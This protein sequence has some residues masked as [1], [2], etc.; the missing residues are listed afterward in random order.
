[1][2]GWIEFFLQGVTET[3]ERAVDTA[4]KI[5]LLREYG[6]KRLATFGRSTEKEMTLYNYL[7]KT[8]MVRVR[9]VEQILNIKNPNALAL[10]AKFVEVGILKELTGHKRNRVFS[11]ADYVALFE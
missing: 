6:I 9:D 3:S 7:F 10:I 4:R 1:M 8:P 11:F 5:I 2:E